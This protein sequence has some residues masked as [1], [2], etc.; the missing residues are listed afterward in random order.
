MKRQIRVGSVQIG[1]GA[2]VSIQSMTNTD[3]RD[4]EATCAQIHALEAAGCEIVRLGIPDEAAALA[5]KE[6]KKRTAVPLVADIH[7]SYRLALICLEGGIDKIRINPGNIGSI[8]KVRYVADAA[9]ERNVPIRIGVNGGSLQKDIL[10]KYGAPCA[11]ALVESALAHASLLEQCGF[12][13]IALSLKSSSVPEMIRA[14]ELADKACGY[15]LHLG[16][17]ETGT[18]HMGLVKSAIGIG[19]LLSHGIGDTIRVSLTDDPVE[20]VYAARDILKALGLRREGAEI[21]SCPTCGRCRIDLIRMAKEVEERTKDIKQ[22]VKLAVMGCAVNG[23][24]EA[25]EADLGIA[26]GDGE[27]LLF[28]KGEI[29]YKVPQEKAVDA[30]MNELES[31][32]LEKGQA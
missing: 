2:P 20:E 7:F 22:S 32:L 28:K 6:I 29:L 8:E 12:Y 11:E 3:T 14:Y 24:G 27:A 23:P 31:W 26:G 25:R 21:V 19:S 30:L 1:G 18:Y 17:T 15:P 16:V 5:V 13:D 10:A 4:V 9:K